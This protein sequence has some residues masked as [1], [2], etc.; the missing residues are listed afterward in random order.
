MY[1][2]PDTTALVGKL[3]ERVAQLT[4]EREQLTADLDA[5]RKDIRCVCGGQHQ[6][7][8]CSAAWWRWE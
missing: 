1:R 2:S 4:Q 5:H 3:K 6:G 8:R 7:C